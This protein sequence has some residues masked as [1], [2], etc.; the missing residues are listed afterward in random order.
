MWWLKLLLCQG[1]GFSGSFLPVAGLANTSQGA[2]PGCMT[3]T[4]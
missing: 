2:R 1:E 3:Q 4:R